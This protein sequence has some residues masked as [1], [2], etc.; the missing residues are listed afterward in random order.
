[1]CN[2]Q[3]EAGA[4]FCGNCGKQVAPLLAQGAT[5]ADHT[6]IIRSNA[7]PAETVYPPTSQPSTPAP[8]QAYRNDYQQQNYQQRTPLA[9]NMPSNPPGLPPAHT[10]RGLSTRTVAFIAIILLL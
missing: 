4:A 10:G 3:L 2:A 1:N 8:P 9:G 6:E 5:V 7:T